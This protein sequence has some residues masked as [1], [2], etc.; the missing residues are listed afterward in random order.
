MP[1]AA[2]PTNCAVQASSPTTITITCKKPDGT[3]CSTAYDTDAISGA[4]AIV[5]VKYNHTL[6]TPFISS[7]LGNVRD[8]GTEHA[9]EGRVR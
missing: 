3:A 5:E 1:N 8:P 9:D 6:I 2:S 4:T 7:L